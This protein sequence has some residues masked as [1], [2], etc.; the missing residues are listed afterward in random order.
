MGVTVDVCAISVRQRL[1]A[2][3]ELV[4]EERALREERL[5]E[6]SLAIAQPMQYILSA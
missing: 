6:V 3:W 1:K 5:H 2:H 4:E